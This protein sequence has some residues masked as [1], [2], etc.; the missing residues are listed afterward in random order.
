MTLE[1]LKHFYRYT[2]PIEV[3]QLLILDGY[4]SHATFRFKKLAYKYKIILLYLPAHITHKLQLL[5]IGIF[6]P[7]S[8]FYSTQITQYSRWTKFNISKREYLD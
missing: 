1:Y 7:Q 2:R 5:D 8:D 3:F 6:G 4:N